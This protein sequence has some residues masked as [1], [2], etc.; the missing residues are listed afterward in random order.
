MFWATAHI[1][2][3]RRPPPPALPVPFSCA[4]S[5][6]SAD[7][8]HGTAGT[9]CLQNGQG[10][11]TEGLSGAAV[12]SLTGRVWVWFYVFFRHLLGG[13]GGQC[14]ELLTAAGPYL[15]LHDRDRRGS[16]P[17][18]HRGTVWSKRCG[19]GTIPRVAW[20]VSEKQC[21]SCFV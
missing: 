14:A 21:S 10:W 11:L 18:G 8:A 17:G 9:D 13:G 1:G 15:L 20:E 12:R 3:S 2:G 6:T 5:A 16:R 7:T 4:T 19:L